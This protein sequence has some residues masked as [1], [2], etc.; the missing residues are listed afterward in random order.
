MHVN[1]SI[2]KPAGWKQSHREQAIGRH[3]DSTKDMEST[4]LQ[5]RIAAHN[6][7]HVGQILGG[8]DAAHFRRVPDE[9]P[10]PAQYPTRTTPY[11]P[12]RGLEF[13]KRKS[14]NSPPERPDGS[15][16]DTSI[17]N[18]SV[19]PPLPT[20]KKPFLE[21]RLPPLI[22]PRKKPTPLEI[23]ALTFPTDFNTTPETSA[24]RATTPSEERHRSPQI[25]ASRFAGEQLTESATEDDDQVIWKLAS[26][27]KLSE[28]SCATYMKNMSSAIRDA[29][30]VAHGERP[31]NRKPKEYSEGD[32]FSIHSVHSDDEERRMAVSGSPDYSRAMSS[33]S[34]AISVVAL[35]GLVTTCIDA[36]RV[37]RSVSH[38]SRSTDFLFLRL[39]VERDIFLQWTQKVG[40]LMKH[41][42]DGNL[43]DHRTDSLIY[44]VLV[45]IRHLLL[46][47]G[48]E[49]R[50]GWLSTVGEGQER[51]IKPQYR[52]RGGRK[53]ISAH[54]WDDLRRARKQVGF[55]SSP[56]WAVHRR[57]ELRGLIDELGSLIWK[58]HQ[59][60]PGSEQRRPIVKE[61]VNEGADEIAVAYP[62][63]VAQPSVA[64]YGASSS[65]S[66][67]EDSA[68][69]GFVKVSVAETG[70]KAGEVQQI[71]GTWNNAIDLDAQPRST[72]I[73]ASSTTLGGLSMLAKQDLP[74]QAYVNSDS[75]IFSSEVSKDAHPEKAKVP[76]V[77]LDR[78]LRA[79]TSVEARILGQLN[80]HDAEEATAGL[81]RTGNMDWVN[82]TTL[83]MTPLSA[84]MIDVI[85]MGWPERSLVVLLIFS[86]VSFGMLILPI[87]TRFKRVKKLEE[88]H[89]SNF[90]I[91]VIMT[92]TV[93]YTLLSSVASIFC[94]SLGHSWGSAI[95]I[96]FLL[97]EFALELAIL[98]LPVVYRLTRP[99][100]GMMRIW[101]AFM[102]LL[103][104]L[105][106]S[107]TMNRPGGDSRQEGRSS[108][109]APS[110]TGSG[111][112]STDED[113]EYSI[114]ARLV[115]LSAKANMAL[116]RKL[117]PPV[118]LGKIRIRYKCACGA[119]L[120]DDYPAYQETQA[121]SLEQKLDRHFRQVES[122]AAGD[123]KAHGFHEIFR[124]VLSDLRHF[125]N[126]LQRRLSGAASEAK[127]DNE[128][129]ELEPV[130]SAVEDKSYYLTSF[131]STGDRRPRLIQVPASEIQGDSAY[132]AML[133]S[134]AQAVQRRWIK[135]LIPR[136]I[137]AIR[138]VQVSAPGF[139]N[140]LALIG[141][142][143][144][145][146]CCTTTNTSTSV[147]AQTR[148]FP[149][150]RMSTIQ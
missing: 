53:N 66:D 143:S 86:L 105:Q 114:F 147:R 75:S 64:S 34:S 4:T 70:R 57:R 106:R 122:R 135:F 51:D 113:Y 29:L 127:V 67:S 119:R 120:W 60:V 77:S 89:H 28:P 21:G 35:S 31:R 17:G 18:N 102:N 149:K 144:R 37:F 74:T 45:R 54:R 7:P 5:Q 81:N 115:S 3:I 78:V 121:R 110:I 101:Q 52:E 30:D 112:H 138:Y 85:V 13:L 59:M 109:S 10:R 43:F 118:L 84:T 41:H 16:T 47:V 80:K 108:I 92:V 137:K 20:R 98:V 39:G 27:S 94:M 42:V 131:P 14:I 56:V 139:W 48:T 111:M 132:F 19:P 58:L 11:A 150:M 12:T 32:N 97:L 50:Y 36:F 83:S 88:Q 62:A 116:S 107:T 68:G 96:R 123:Y 15:I 128:L 33:T 90:N 40:V 9:L 82:P 124:L 91:L 23:S 93:I 130:P 71:S 8:L 65:T 100:A 146:I 141:D 25:A 55:R 95:A 126:S 140:W 76:K 1:K 125:S 26:E 142:P 61:A 117:E 104:A 129:Q 38:P 145:C 134:Q 72:A 49:G 6:A 73:E 69:L 103:P 2:D 136:K 63:I 133:R 46:E 99:R 24:N 79:N 22:R 87:C 148:S 44:V